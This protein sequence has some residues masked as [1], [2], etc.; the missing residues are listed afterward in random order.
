M[1]IN[2]QLVG[3]A[4]IILS[5]GAVFA[6]EG[7]PAPNLGPRVTV[8]PSPSRPLTVTKRLFPDDATRCAR[9]KLDLWFSQGQYTVSYFMLGQN[10]MGRV[11]AEHTESGSELLIG[12]PGCQYRIRI[13]AVRE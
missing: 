6:Q 7:R 1:S 3:S 8:P 9:G 2:L 5:V 4:I 13:D 10:D 11:S 12:D